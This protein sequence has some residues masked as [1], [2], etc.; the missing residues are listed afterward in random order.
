MNKKHQKCPINGVFPPLCDPPRFFFKNLALSLLY[1]YDA[2]TSLKKLEKTDGWSLRYLKTYT[3]TDTHT[4]KGNYK[5]PLRLNPGFK[6][7]AF[8]IS[9]QPNLLQSQ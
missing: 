6:I 1:P 5:G 7:N 9:M 3:H 2:L 8:R 4:D